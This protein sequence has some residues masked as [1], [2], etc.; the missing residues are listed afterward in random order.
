MLLRNKAKCRWRN[1]LKTRD[2]SL[3]L[4]SG[5]WSDAGMK[6]WCQL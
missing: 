2:F 5:G 6:V 3:D 4:V 1:I